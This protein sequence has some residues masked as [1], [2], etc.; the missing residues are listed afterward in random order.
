MPNFRG[1]MEE[2]PTTLQR[3]DGWL[4]PLRNSL[5]AN[6]LLSSRTPVSRLF[7]RAPPGTMI[8]LIGLD[9]GGKTTLLE[10]YVS[11][12]GDGDGV[13]SCHPFIGG[14]IE[15]VR[16]GP[17]AF[18]AYDI[19]GCRPRGIHSYDQGMFKQAHAVVW[20]VD[21]A[22]RDRTLESREELYEHGFHAKDGKG[23]QP[24][25]PLLVLATKQD[26]EGARTAEQLE[27]FFIH[28]I[29]TSVGKRPTH[30]A[31]INTLTGEGVLEAFTWLSDVLL[32]KPQAE[33][34]QTEKPEKEEKPTVTKTSSEKTS[35]ASSA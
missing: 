20:V 17:V 29:A 6:R 35:L 26:R 34:E 28:N 10:R 14:H 33:K 27:T 30:V 32:N 11:Q 3:L 13:Q 12:T 8:L 15:S 31:G 4:A 9:C 23:I 2:T 19:G 24:G 7:D 16:Y 21:A 18:L 22:D 1:P 25:V 5:I